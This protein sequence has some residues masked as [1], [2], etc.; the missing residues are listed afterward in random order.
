[1]NLV[2]ARAA[3]REA[4]TKDSVSNVVS[5]GVVPGT[6]SG[7]VPSVG[8]SGVSDQSATSTSAATSSASVLAK[9]AYPPPAEVP[10]QHGARGIQFDFNDGCRVVLP[11]TSHPWRVRL[12]DLDTGN[13]LYETELKA[14]GVNS[15]KRYYVR[16]RLE[17]WQQGESVF[18]HDYSAADRKVLVQFPAGTLGDTVGWFPYAV[19]FKQKHG[20]RLTCG[21]AE[22]L[23]P[24]FRDAY[25]DISFVT[26]EE[27]KPEQYYATYCMGLFFDDKDF[28]F[29]PCDFRH[30]GLHRTAGYILGV[31]PT[32]MP[33]ACCGKNRA[34]GAEADGFQFLISKP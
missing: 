12:S 11:D 22:R 15:T 23:I 14:G 7:S 17:V 30:V 3:L 33:P 2:A 31:D 10:T 20:C 9:R 21:M 32:E 28:M 34:R 19:K 18:A 6:E 26:H 27:I 4:D 13:I 25:P 24:L 5:I 29:Q 1:M 8:E 16:F